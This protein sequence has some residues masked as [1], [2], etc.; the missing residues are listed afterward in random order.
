[1]AVGTVMEVDDVTEAEL[2]LALATITASDTREVV[3]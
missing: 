3:A 1:M 2:D